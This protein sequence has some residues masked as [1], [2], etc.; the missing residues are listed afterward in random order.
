VGQSSRIGWLTLGILVLVS[1]RVANGQKVVVVAGGAAIDVDERATILKPGDMLRLRIWKEPDF[2]GDYLIDEH[3]MAVLPRLGN[4]AV[5]DIPAAQLR[6]R[7][8]EQ[9]REYLNNPTIEVTPL[10]RI[11]IIGAVRNPGVYRIEPG[12]TLGEVINVAGGPTTQSKRNVVE[13]RHGAERRTID[14]EHHPELA[15]VSLASNDQVYVPERSWLNQNATWFVST[16]V[17]V[18]GTIVFLV[19]R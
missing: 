5:A 19:T 3:G 12:V 16:L 9:Y 1:P 15:T 2:S 17:G 10:R 14:L 18:G 7:L 8:I 11:S 4:T 13:L 6:L